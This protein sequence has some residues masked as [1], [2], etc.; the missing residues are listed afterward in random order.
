M[1]TPLHFTVCRTAT[2][3]APARRAIIAL[4]AAAWGS[5]DFE[6]LFA[7]LQP[8]DEHI[9]GHLDGI[10][11]AHAVISPR[12]LKPDD[13]PALK[14]ACVD[15]VATL[16]AQQR[17]GYG[18]ALMHYLAQHIATDYD[19]GWLETGRQSR[20]YRRAGWQVWYG[21]LVTRSAAGHLRTVKS[22]MQRLLLPLPGTPAPA[23]GARL[24]LEPGGPAAPRPDEPN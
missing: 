4:C 3:D 1:P 5:D 9:L 17:K 2:L 18:T 10:L 21:D 14:A 15:A 19:M 22:A 16:P 11:I 8:Q 13:Q 12:W 20:F 23:P 6:R 24:I 7:Y